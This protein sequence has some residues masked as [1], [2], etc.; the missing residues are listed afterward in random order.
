METVVHSELSNLN[1]WLTINKLTLNAKK[2]NYVICRPHQKRLPHSII[3]ILDNKINAF[4]QLEQNTYIK[5]LGIFFD[6]NLSWKFHNLAPNLE[7]DLIIL[8]I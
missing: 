8:N 1:E 3:K 6:E 2:S 4:V 7:N 5:Y